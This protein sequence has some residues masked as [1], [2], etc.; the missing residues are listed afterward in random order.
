MK[1]YNFLFLV[2][3]ALLFSCKNHD[4][5][6]GKTVFRY[7]EAANITTLDPAFARDQA[8]IWATNQLFNGLVQLNDRLE[9]GPCIASSWEISPSGLEYVFHLRHDVFFHD[10]PAFKNRKGRRVVAPDFVYSFQRIIDPSVASPGAWIFNNISKDQEKM[11]FESLDD[12]TLVVRL[13]KPFPPFLGLLSMQYCSV[14]PYEAVDYF[15]AAFRSNPVGTGPFKFKMWE[16]GVKLIL[17]KNQGYFE[18]QDGDRLPFLDAVAITF[19]ADKQSAFLEFVKGKLDFISGIDPT[20][21]DELLTR[22]GKLQPKYASRIVLYTQ[23]YLNTEYLGFMVDTTGQT[24]NPS[25]LADRRVRQAINQ[26]FDRKKMIRYLRNNIGTPGNQGITPKGLPSFDSSHI[27]YDFNPEKAIQLLASAGYPGGR[28]LP[29]FTLTSTSDYLDICKYIQHQVATIG[30]S[31]KI[32]VSPPASV[33]EMKAQGKLSFFRASWIADYPDAENYLSMFYYKNFC[34]RGPNY[35]HF[36]NRDFD[37]L[38]EKSMSTVNDSLRLE[39]Y[40][41]MEKIMMEEAPVV[42]LYYDQVLRFVQ[43]NIR[44]LGT[45]PMNLLTLKKVRKL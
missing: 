39:Y 10:S 1:Y 38:F 13:D 25:A 31:L 30:I 36:S 6:S 23:P 29:E 3:F 27:F 9:A 18:Y 32:D 35:T 14:I 20:Y 12:S 45:N 28:G 42:I 26:A 8:I 5:Q 33:K 22:E 40:Q 16:E 15:G 11:P 21:K 7:N 4:R 37:R 24:K 17:V 34:P 43:K 41:Q 44:G 19:V 2:S